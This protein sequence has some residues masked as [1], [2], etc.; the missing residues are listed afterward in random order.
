MRLCPHDHDK[1]VVG[2][3]ASGRCKECHRLSVIKYNRAHPDRRAVTIS[4]WQKAHPEQHHSIQNRSARKRYAQNPEP[5]RASSAKWR[6]DNYDQYLHTQQ[7]Y[8]DTLM[9]ALA[10]SRSVRKRETAA[11]SAAV[12]Q[13]R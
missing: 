11:L 7:R 3:T 13:V 12:E 6:R 5:H 8:K 1:D 2:T 10:E 9:G 4:N